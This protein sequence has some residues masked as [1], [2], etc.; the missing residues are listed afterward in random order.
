MIAVTNGS[1][2]V[3][4]T[5]VNKDKWDTKEGRSKSACMYNRMVKGASRA[6]VA[7]NSKKIKPIALATVELWLLRESEGIRQAG[8]QLVSQLVEN[9][10]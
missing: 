7:L 4:S 1:H 10:V 5:V 3:Q 2:H 8:R 6:E 9:S